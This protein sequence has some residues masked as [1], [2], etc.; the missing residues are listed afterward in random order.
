MAAP[1]LALY[2]TPAALLASGRTSFPTGSIVEAGGYR[3]EVVT[4]GEVLT[5]AGGAKLVPVRNAG[6]VTTTQLGCEVVATSAEAATA[7]DATDVIQATL[8]AGIDVFLDGRVRLAGLLTVDGRVVAGIGHEQAGFYCTAAASGLVVVGQGSTVRDLGIESDYTA[9]ILVEVGDG[10]EGT[11]NDIVLDNLFVIGAKLRCLRV[12]EFANPKV[13]TRSVFKRC[14]NRNGTTA[15][16]D[17]GSHAIEVRCITQFVGCE[18]SSATGRSL[19][20]VSRSD[21]EE[22][23]VY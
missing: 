1:A 15:I 6:F 20:V 14:G 11:T 17:V 9:E 4:S 12:R 5:T 23:R 8:D 19:Y 22:S 7:D 18:A 10:V 2:P 16:I 21:W 3:Y 13:I